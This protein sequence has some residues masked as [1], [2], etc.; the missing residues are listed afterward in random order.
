MKAYRVVNAELH[1]FLTSGLDRNEWTASCHDQFTTGEIIH[2]YPVNRK[3][4]EPQKHLEA[5]KKSEV[6]CP[7]W[8]LNPYD[9]EIALV[10]HIFITTLNGLS[11]LLKHEECVLKL[12]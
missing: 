7:S 2:W 10:I 9:R 6:F 5:L 3:L 12:K 1:T 4:G 11:Q 8:E